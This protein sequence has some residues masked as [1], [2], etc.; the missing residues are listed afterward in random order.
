[1]KFTIKFASGGGG[2][3]SPV[4]PDWSLTRF[5]GWYTTIENNGKVNEAKNYLTGKME[6]EYWWDIYIEIKYLEQLVK[7]SQHFNEALVVDAKDMSITVYDD[8]L[9]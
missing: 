3:W 6:K 5:N 9:E 2:C 4:K 8:Y 1:M 7:L